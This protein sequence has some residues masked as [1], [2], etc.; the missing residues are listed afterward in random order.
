MLVY[1]NNGI[2]STPL[3]DVC[4][5]RVLVFILLELSQFQKLCDYFTVGVQFDM[6]AYQKVNM[7]EEAQVPK[8]SAPFSAIEVSPDK[9]YAG[10]VRGR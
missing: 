6:T 10:L 3:Y 5:P 8:R 7:W 4:T 9:C 1:A 2:K